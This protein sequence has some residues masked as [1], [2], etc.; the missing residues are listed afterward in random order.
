VRLEELVEEI[1]L[2]TG[3]RRRALLANEHLNTSHT[4]RHLG[5]TQAKH[6]VRTGVLQVNKA[7]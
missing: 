1:N 4:H 7:L 6:L 5:R 2:T 3:L